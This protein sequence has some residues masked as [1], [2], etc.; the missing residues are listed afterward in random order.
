MK[1]L[2][3]SDVKWKYLINLAGQAFPMKTNEEL[4]QILKVF[5]GSNDAAG[6]T[7]E[8][9]IRKRYFDCNP[10]PHGTMTI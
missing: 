6:R 9:V 2:V 10:I 7:G 4:V 1:D 8:A 5:N 3:R